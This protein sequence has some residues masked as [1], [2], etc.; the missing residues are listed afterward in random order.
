M[1]KYNDNRHT[2]ALI[3]NG[4]DMAHWYKT[5]YRSFVDQTNDPNLDYFRC[6]CENECSITT[7]Y[8]LEESIRILTEKLFLQSYTEKCNYEANRKEAERLRTAFQNIHVLLLQY[9]EKETSRKPVEKLASVERYLTGSTAINFNYTKVA[10]AY[11]KKV[12]YVHGSLE[13]RDILLGYDFR[14]EPCLAEYVDLCWSKTI[15]REQLAF[16]RF[17]RKHRRSDDQMLHSGLEAYQQWEN[18]GRGIEEEASSFIP[19]YHRVDRILR[20]IRKHGEI[21]SLKYRR[22]KTI[23]VMGHGIKSDQVFL[24]KIVSAC[25]KLERI[26]IFRYNG[27]TDESFNAKVDFFRPY[28]DEIQTVYY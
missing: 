12:I 2:L 6:C 11:T 3:G 27:E 9:L 15:C 19:E 23:V 4:F 13:E 16:R 25:S 26:V 18:S 21:P 7:W 8:W 1:R 22:V 5:D 17:L 20:R 24:Q 14:P 28:C 10:R